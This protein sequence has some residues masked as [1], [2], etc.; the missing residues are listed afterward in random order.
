M[1]GSPVKVAADPSPS[2]CLNT[3]FETSSVTP[4]G[5]EPASLIWNM[6]VIS[7]RFVTVITYGT[8]LLL[9]STRNQL[10]ML[11]GSNVPQFDVSSQ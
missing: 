6:P 1:K 8:V 7:C 10:S 9:R 11:S 5:T 4:Y 3:P 2:T